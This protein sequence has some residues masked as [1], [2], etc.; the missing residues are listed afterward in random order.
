MGNR[1]AWRCRT[2]GRRVEERGIAD[3]QLVGA[4]GVNPSARATRQAPP[5]SAWRWF[6]RSMTPRLH[7][8]RRRACRR[9][10]DSFTRLAARYLGQPGSTGA[11][12][13]RRGPSTGNRDV[14]TADLRFRRNEQIRLEIPTAAAAGG[15]RAC[16]IAAASHSCRSAAAL[17]DDSGSGGRPPSLRW[18][19][20][21]GDYVIEISEGERRTLAAWVVQ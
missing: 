6:R 19:P 5:P 1:R 20:R 9:C 17:R 11:A 16:W 12:W 7:D 14:A 8:S 3:V 4:S 10:R 21:P 15:R 18:R 13:I 2:D